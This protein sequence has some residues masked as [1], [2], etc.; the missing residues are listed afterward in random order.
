MELRYFNAPG[1]SVPTV[2]SH[3]LDRVVRKLLSFAGIRRNVTKDWLGSLHGIIS[4]FP[5]TIAG[6]EL[7]R[8]VPL[9][10]KVL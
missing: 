9:S 4:G 10:E 1:K 5:S 2:L 6:C 7:Q 3:E 8:T